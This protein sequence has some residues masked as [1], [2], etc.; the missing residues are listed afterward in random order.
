MSPRCNCREK[1]TVNVLRECFQITRI[2]WRAMLESRVIDT[3]LRK[4]KD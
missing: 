1:L 2:C 3:I 4:K